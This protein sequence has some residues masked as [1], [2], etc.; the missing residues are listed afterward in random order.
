MTMH[1]D[2]DLLNAG[3]GNATAGNWQQLD[4]ADLPPTLSPENQEA[5]TQGVH[6][7]LGVHED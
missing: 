1:S 3:G 5:E 6:I 4:S 7:T 2:P